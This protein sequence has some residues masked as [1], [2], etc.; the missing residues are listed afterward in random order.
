MPVEK[1]PQMSVEKISTPAPGIENGNVCRPMTGFPIPPYRHNLLFTAFVIAAVAIQL[2][3]V[4][5]VF[6]PHAPVVAIAVS[7]VLSFGTPLCR[8]LLH[9]AIHGRLASNKNWNV[10]LGRILGWCSGAAFDGIRLGHLTHH[11][12]PRHHL[13]QADII[14]PGKSRTQINV[15]FYFDLLGG[16]YLRE[17]LYSLVMLFPRRTI[18]RVAEYL[19]ANDGSES[20]A[21]YSALQRGLDR[22]L[23][24]I[25]IDMVCIVLIYAAAFYLY[26]EWW[27]TLLMGIALRGLILSLQDN[28]AHYGTPAFVGAAA[29]NTQASRLIRLFMLNQNFHGLHHDRPELPWNVLPEAFERAGGKYAGGYFKLLAKQFYGPRHESSVN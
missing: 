15:I 7:L 17:I 18:N 11:R 12:F 29:H 16:I 5:L 2:F 14:Q 10:G 24:R 8:A 25:R 13:D 23:G 9:E 1:I 6:L 4:P 28:V 20:D 3:V 19:M 21:L 27:P 26:G 22:R